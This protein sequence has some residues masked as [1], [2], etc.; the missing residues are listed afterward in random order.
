MKRFF[1]QNIRTLLGVLA[2]AVAGY[3][4]WAYVGC[5]SG[6][7]PITSSPWMSSLWG[8]LIGFTLFPLRRSQRDGQEGLYKD[9]IK[10]YERK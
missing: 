10:K 5:A 9:V 6:T 4:Y 1:R 2:G 7:C 8:G 3:L